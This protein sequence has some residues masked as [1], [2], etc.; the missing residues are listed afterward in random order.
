MSRRLAR[1]QELPSE[2]SRY[3]VSLTD[4]DLHNRI[5]DLYDAGWTLQSI[6]NALSPQKRRSTVKSW[7]DRARL[8]RKI[9]LKTET[10]DVLKKPIPLPQHKT[11]PRGYQRLTPKSP[12]V[13]SYIQ[14]R[15]REVAPLAQ[16]YRARMSSSSPAALANQEMDELVRSLKDHDVSIADIARAA[17]VTHRAIAKRLERLLER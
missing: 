14:E 8:L 9:D 6:G 4:V 3:L 2:E 15:L 10:T 1:S 5:L 16:Q 11:D 17:N 12:G 13:P 7:V